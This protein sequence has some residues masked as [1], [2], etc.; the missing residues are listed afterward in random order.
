MIKLN[1]KYKSLILG[2]QRYHIISG[3]RAS[4]KSYSV[5][6]YLLALTLEKGNVILFSR[7]TMSSVKISVFPE[8]IDKIEQL[9]LQEH[10]EI[11]NNEIINKTTGSK[12]IFKGIKTGSNLQTANLKSI[13]NLNIVVIDEAEEIPDEATF[14][15]IDLSAR[16]N[17]KDN[18]IILIFNP[19]S[20][21]HWI[22]ERFF[23]STGVEP[24][25]CTIT[26]DTNYIH[27]TYLD[28][29]KYL[30]E[31]ILK[32]FNKI[33]NTNPDK[34]NHIILGAFLDVAEGVI[35]KNWKV[36]EFPDNLEYHYG[37]DFGFSPDYDTLTK[38]A[39]DK[40]NM[41]IYVHECIYANKLSTPELIQ[42]VKAETKNKLVIADNSANRLISELENGGINIQGCTKGAGSIEEGIKLMLDYE[43][44]VTASSTNIMKE[45]N[46]YIWSN[47][48]A[49]YP[50]DMYNHSIDGIRYIV[51]HLLKNSS[52]QS[53]DDFYIM[54]F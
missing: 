42:L 1:K 52:P 28:N 29:Q 18:K 12:I 17:D 46:N 32:Q 26:E 25:I 23:E 31:S 13:A 45:F 11:T 51:T 37:Q 44:I 15:K 49:G 20:K 3:G 19:T 40:V 47:K 39:I 8:F 53:A 10:Y 54:N 35:F 4:G 34:Y 2:K 50:R 30:S 41:K 48:K 21:A 22:Y 24:G 7:Y 14:D 33:K 27:S 43:I 36:G 16:R 6:A 9:N 38:V 5:A